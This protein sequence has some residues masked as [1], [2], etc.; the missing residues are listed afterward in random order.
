MLILGDW[1]VTTPLEPPRPGWG[2][3]VV[4]E[5]VD[6]VGPHAALRL[7]FPDDPVF[8]GRGRIVLPGFVNAHQHL[9]AVLAHGIPADKAPADFW[10]FLADF[11]WPLIEDALDQP[12]LVAAADWSCAEMLGG[13]TTSF[14]DC[15]EAPF[16]LPGA[17]ALQR[18]VVERYGMRARLSF[19]ATERVSPENGQLGLRENA[20]FID[21][22]R[23][24]GGLV[25][26]MMCCH[27]SFT[28]SAQFI[29]Q[30]FELAAE[31]GV[32]TQLHVSEGVHE[33][34]YALEQFGLRPLEYYASLGLTGPGMLASQCAQISERER[35]I[36]VEHGVHVS[37]I[38]LGNSWT[39]SGL[40]PVPELLAANV[41]L[42]LG[43]NGFIND[44]FQ[45]A[46]GAVLLHRSQRGAVQA[47]TPAQA[48]FLA[49]EGGARALGLRQ[50]GRLEPGWAAD[51]QLVDAALP[52]PAAEHNL[53]DQLVFWRERTHV[54]DVMVAG[55]WRVRDGV[56][57]GADS[58][59][60]RARVH[61]QAA[62][63]WSR[64]SR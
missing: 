35:E 59:Q 12:M 4:G 37:H 50:V 26:G 30:T 21:A 6:A 14:Y 49:T 28:C 20:D 13:G 8:D 23:Q 15:L 9:Y 29:R 33:P 18:E 61:E 43:T 2:L 11:W 53:Y 56:V 64:G 62:R 22:C 25:Q 40:A 34:D 10:A 47:L 31:R 1:L 51:L 44:M 55:A 41:A 39:G 3:R 16:A 17:L 32:L 58:E 45:V 38:P 7:V 36:I 42:G 54:R 63:L 24:A 60:L 19:E 57:L 5:T 27:T 46:R 48:L 52:S